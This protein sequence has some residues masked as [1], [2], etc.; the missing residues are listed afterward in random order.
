MSS[1]PP[2]APVSSKHEYPTSAPGQPSKPVH[3]SEPEHSEDCESD[4]PEATGYPSKPSGAWPAGPVNTP[5][6]PSNGSTP[7][8]STGGWATSPSAP[9]ATYTP[10]LSNDA[11]RFTMSF[12]SAVIALGA[13]VM[14]L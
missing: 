4:Y 6:G 12:G 14:L 2:T 8:Y 13:A 11:G 10:I 9:T 7:A 1:K 5:Y 3:P